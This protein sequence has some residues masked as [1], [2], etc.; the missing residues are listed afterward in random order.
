MK[1]VEL[2]QKG[3]S[4]A[5]RTAP[6]GSVWNGESGH[7]ATGSREDSGLR[8]EGCGDGRR[9]ESPRMP[10]PARVSTLEVMM[11]GPSS[12]SAAP[13]RR[14]A[15]ARIPGRLASGEIRTGGSSPSPL[16]HCC[17]TTPLWSPARSSPSV[18]TKV[19]WCSDGSPNERMARRVA[20]SAWVNVRPRADG[21]KTCGRSLGRHPG[22][23]DPIIRTAVRLK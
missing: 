13:S 7:S 9:H 21:E 4:M 23:V 2:L 8:S 17:Q 12:L 10:R 15:H 3:P 11:G 5:A 14:S 22:Q 16:P 18:A 19:L 1:G 6:T 20:W